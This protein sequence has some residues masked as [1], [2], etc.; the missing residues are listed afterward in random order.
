M[1]KFLKAISV[2]SMMAAVAACSTTND[3]SDSVIEISSPSVD[4]VDGDTITRQNALATTV[5]YFG[6]DS[7]ELDEQDRATLVYH[8]EQLRS[9]PNSIIRLEGHA[10]EE[11]TREYNLTLGENRAEA[12]SMFLIVNGASQ[13]QIEVISYGEE[14][15]ANNGS[16]EEDRALNRRVEIK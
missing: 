13:S 12:V 1:N 10:S 7:S 15:P 3:S 11:G 6:F 16:T 8:A 2:L 14:K 4:S 9:N 5:F